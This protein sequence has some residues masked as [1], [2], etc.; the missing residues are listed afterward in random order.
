[1]RVSYI[2]NIYLG[3]L[4]RFKSLDTKIFSQKEMRTFIHKNAPTAH[5]IIT[6]R[7]VN[8]IYFSNLIRIDSNMWT[9]HAQSA[10]WDEK[11]KEEHMEPNEKFVNVSEII[12]DILNNLIPNIPTRCKV[13]QPIQCH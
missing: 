3:L 10:R 4:I 11:V 9:T 5:R 7:V 8:F 12:R 2:H 13:V 1:M 6:V